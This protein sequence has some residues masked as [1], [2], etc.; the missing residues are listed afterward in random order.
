ML[1]LCA[2]LSAG[3]SGSI[4]INGDNYVVDT[5]FHNVI[6]PGTTQTSLW[7]HNS[8]VNLR[9]FYSTVD[10][11][12]PY[13]S[14]ECIIGR[15]HVPSCQNL[16][17]MSR[18]HTSP[19]HKPFI[20]INGDFFI[21]YSAHTLRGEAMY[22]APSGPTIC[23]GDIMITRA[24]PTNYMSFTSDVNGQVYVGNFAFTGTFIG[25][26]N[27]TVKASAVNPVQSTPE[28]NA[29]TIYNEFYYSSSNVAGGCEVT[30][31]LAEGEKFQATGTTH[32]V[33]TSEPNTEGD[34]LI[35]AGG[36]VLHARGTSAE[37]F[38]KSLKP[39]DEL[40]LETQ[41][42]SDGVNIIPDQVISG[43]PRIL[44]GGEILDT[45]SSRGDG[46]SRHPRTS[47]G[48]SDGGKKV[49]L[50]VVD[51]RQSLSAGIRTSGLA[52]IMRYAGATEAMNLDGG[53]SSVLYSSILGERN[54][55]SEGSLRAVGNAM[56]AV[57]NAPDDNELAELR[58]QD[59]KLT[60]SRYAVYT[61]HFFGYNKYGELINTDVKGVTISC[62]EGFGKIKNDTTF[63]ATGIGTDLITA[64]LGNVEVSMPMVIVG[65]QL[66]NMA[67]INDSI[68]TDGLRDQLIDVQTLLDG[69]VMPLSPEA[70]L[71]ESLNSNIVKIDPT[72]GVLRGLRDG[73][74]QVIGTVDG[75]ADTML[76]NVEIPKARVMKADDLD[77]STWT[78]TMRAG[79]EGVATQLG[80]GGF[81]WAFTGSSG[82]LP[83][84]TMKKSIRLW[85]L[86]DTLRLRFN[87]GN[88]PIKQLVF[89]LYAGNHRLA[90]AIVALNDT[91]SGKD[92]VIDLPTAQWC[93][94]SDMANFPITLSGIQFDMFSSTNGASYKMRLDAI[95]TVYSR[96][97]N[98]SPALKGD[99]DASG[100]VD[101]DDVNAVINL[102]LN[103]DQYK[104]KYPGI[105]DLDGNGMIDV[106]DVNALINIILKV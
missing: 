15:D 85:S 59:Y 84:I 56:F 60:T 46:S 22:G 80:D 91:T 99:V 98:V 32:F 44:S 51:G 105:G 33:V 93:N 42:T 29:I 30:A 52:A 65:E 4:V 27:S 73:S 74:T 76:V 79:K 9:A 2:A 14:L 10:L 34:M 20:G 62:P 37:N 7:I 90:T 39:G 92:K 36:V 35:P 11:G 67:F 48:Y 49:Y 96:V 70:L 41:C 50:C 69:S 16:E 71:W 23:D 58:F 75:I 89:S 18:H 28:N 5:L 106:D 83:G 25:P 55:P 97:P 72:T 88:V 38:L 64:R 86:P 77:A 61:P 87:N 102:I 45:E 68:V 21:N 8:S 57:S 47:I 101:V 19:G 13:M 40:T 54:H 43:F 26:D 82:R 66:D 81:E 78:M 53:G 104:D 100:I 1:M 94:P 31:M 6:G 95:E 17:S 63:F 103:F 12:N 3:A 24:D